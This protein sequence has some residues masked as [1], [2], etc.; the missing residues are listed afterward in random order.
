MKEVRFQCEKGGR[1]PSAKSSLDMNT[2]IQIGMC[3]NSCQVHLHRHVYVY[4]VE[5][6]IYTPAKRTVVG[7]Q[8]MENNNNKY[9]SAH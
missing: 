3:K 4:S 8:G 5:G 7:K 2:K 9:K 1:Q 6:D